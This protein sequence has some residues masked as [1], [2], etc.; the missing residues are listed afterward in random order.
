MQARVGRGAPRAALRLDF[1]LVPGELARLLLLGE[2]AGESRDLLMA[3]LPQGA[4]LV[5]N[6]STESGRRVSQQLAE[7]VQLFLDADGRALLLLEAVAQ[8]VK[9][10]L[11][12]GIGLLEPGAILEELHEA[13]FFR[14]RAPRVLPNLQKTQLI[15]QCPAPDSSEATDITRHPKP[16]RS[17]VLAQRNIRA[18]CLTSCC[19][20]IADPVHA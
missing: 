15:D 19:G 14:T 8:Q 20:P 4:Q 3:G 9:F 1:F 5:E 16:V 13:L 2:F 12:I 11:E 17:D 7:C 18:T 6:E 10:V